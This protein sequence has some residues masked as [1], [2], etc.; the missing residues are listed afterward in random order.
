MKRVFPVQFV[1][2]VGEDQDG[3][4]AGHPPDEVTERIKR[5]VV[6]PVDVLDHENR[7]MFGPAQLRP[8][9]GMHPVAIA[10]VHHGPAELGLY[11]AHQVADGPRVRGV[12]RSSQ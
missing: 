10:A 1:I 5:G 6:C 9:G 11:A 4:Q 2:T 12:A 3:R 8:Q 7:R